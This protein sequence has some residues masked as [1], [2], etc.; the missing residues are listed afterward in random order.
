[1]SEF[2]NLW[3]SYHLHNV[4]LYPCTCTL[5][6][7]R[8]F[9]STCTRHLYI[10]MCMMCTAALLFTNHNNLLLLGPLRTA[11]VHALL[12]YGGNIGENPSTLIFQLYGNPTLCDHYISSKTTGQDRCV[13]SVCVCVCVCVCACMKIFQYK[14]VATLVI[15]HAY[16]YVSFSLQY[17]GNFHPTSPSSLSH[18]SSM[19]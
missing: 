2:S 15:T 13:C 6:P 11:S 17:S 1:M 7:S 16:M 14:Q 3:L 9:C 10:Y 5:K 19:L 8:M 12:Q 4:M 18:Y